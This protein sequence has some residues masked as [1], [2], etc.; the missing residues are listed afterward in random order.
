MSA[1]YTP[2]SDIPAVDHP[3]PFGLDQVGNDIRNALAPL[4]WNERAYG[5]ALVRELSKG[6]EATQTGAVYPWVWT[7]EDT[8]PVNIGQN[9][10]YMGYTFCYPAGSDSVINQKAQYYQT[11]INVIAWCN[12]TKAFPN[13]GWD[14]TEQIKNEVIRAIEFMGY[15]SLGGTYTT[16]TE[17]RNVYRDFRGVYRDF[18]FENEDV[19]QILYPYTAIRLEYDVTYNMACHENN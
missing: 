11:R 15:S 9:D 3:N 10:S 7:G 19:R 6:P 8:Q 13:E 1:Q 14:H 2:Q 4:S 5:M 16:G 18:R 17:L 12:Q